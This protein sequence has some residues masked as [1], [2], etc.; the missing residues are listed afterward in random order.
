MRENCTN[1]A[2]RYDPWALIAG[3]SEGPRIQQLKAQALE[4]L[5]QA[6]EPI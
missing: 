5:R 1:L 6:L 3:G 4:E 2:E